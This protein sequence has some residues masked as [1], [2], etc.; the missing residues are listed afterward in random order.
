M[1]ERPLLL[2]ATSSRRRHKHAKA[3]ASAE[4]NVVYLKTT[5]KEKPDAPRY[6]E[7][8]QIMDGNTTSEN[9]VAEEFTA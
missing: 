4:R 5:G 6:L 2:V 7:T 9:R 3:L 1:T 8:E